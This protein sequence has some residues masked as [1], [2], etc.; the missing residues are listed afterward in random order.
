MTC[1]S[2]RLL[3][4]S[5]WTVQTVIND[6]CVSKLF[7]ELSGLAARNML[8]WQHPI[9]PVV[10]SI[11]TI[12]FC[13]MNF[14]GMLVQVD[15]R[16]LGLISVRTGKKT[17]QDGVWCGFS[18]AALGTEGAFATYDLGDGWFQWLWLL[19]NDCGLLWRMGTDQWPWCYHAGFQWV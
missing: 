17:R 15:C 7:A 19:I 16:G 2:S 11:S 5:C 10:A 6:V 1:Y 4:G 8:Q 14:L 18:P 9:D 12:W 3:V 13:W